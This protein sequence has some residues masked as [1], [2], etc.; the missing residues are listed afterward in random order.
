MKVRILEA[1]HA[2]RDGTCETF[3][4]GE[5]AD[6]PQGTAECLVRS[7]KALPIEETDVTFAADVRREQL[8][9]ILDRH[10][11]SIKLVADH[12]GLQDLHHQYKDLVQRLRDALEEVQATRELLETLREDWSDPEDDVPKE[13]PSRSTIRT[14][15]KELTKA[16][17]H[18]ESLQQAL[19]TT[20]DHFT[21]AL[22]AAHRRAEH[23]ARAAHAHLLEEAVSAA[24]T[25]QDVLSDLVRFEEG[26]SDRIGPRLGGVPE[27]ERWI[28]D[29]ETLT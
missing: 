2:N 10:D 29:A 17:E 3:E 25:F 23:D 15:E 26:F 8:A 19:H 24:R 22:D 12:D 18:V 1:L 27:L 14:V 7:R 4:R 5:V 11:L 28:Q 13:A 16:E 9:S 20:S 6:L 21:D